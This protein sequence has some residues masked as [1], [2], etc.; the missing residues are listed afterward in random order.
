M[1]HEVTE[2]TRETIHVLDLDRTPRPQKL[3]AERAYFDG[4]HEVRFTERTFRPRHDASLDEIRD[5][6]DSLEVR[7]RELPPLPQ[8]PVSVPVNVRP[9]IP[10][11]YREPLE[12]A[13]RGALISVETVHRVGT[14]IVVDVAWESADEGERRALYLIEDGVARPYEAVA[15]TVDALPVPATAA[16]APPTPEPAAE[17][18]PGAA[19]PEEAK[20]KKGLLGRFGRK[21]A[22]EPRPEPAPQPDAPASDAPAKKR[23]FGFGRGK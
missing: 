6:V 12:A 10:D 16:P 23:R 14:G 22:P 9:K 5:F 18:A 11:H 17:P 21:S 15:S 1:P 2:E 20:P 3:A 4:A 13:I 7:R 8:A 19:T